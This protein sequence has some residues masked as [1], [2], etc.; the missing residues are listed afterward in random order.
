MN[1][2]VGADI[3][4]IVYVLAASSE[5]SIAQQFGNDA[6]MWIF[7]VSDYDKAHVSLD[8]V[9]SFAKTIFVFCDYQ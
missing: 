9:F 2:Y 4:G 5:L 8:N 3:F 7:T 1:V 6:V